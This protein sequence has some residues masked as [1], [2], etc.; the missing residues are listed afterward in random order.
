MEAGR[1][2]MEERTLTPQR[3]CCEVK[4][5]QADKLESWQTITLAG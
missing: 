1:G 3:P 5:C 2:E 4:N